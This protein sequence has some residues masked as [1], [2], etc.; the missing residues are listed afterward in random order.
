MR[1]LARS[2]TF[3]ILAALATSASAWAQG[4]VVV[5]GGPPVVYAPTTTVVTRS[6][7]PR[8][9]YVAAP[10][11]VYYLPGRGVVTTTRT[12]LVPTSALIPARGAYV[13]P[14]FAPV[15][16]EVIRPHRTKVVYPRRV[17]RYVY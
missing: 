8:R 17:V 5:I 9:T 14:A 15:G 13:D 2:L 4:P 1:M 12:V 3:A 10:A 7:V 6:Y 16:Y 11:P